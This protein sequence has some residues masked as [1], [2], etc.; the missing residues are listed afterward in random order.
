MIRP[1]NP[2]FFFLHASIQKLV[3]P[4]C[5]QALSILVIEYTGLGNDIGNVSNNLMGIR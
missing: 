2:Q 4:A 1:L 3:A 5:S